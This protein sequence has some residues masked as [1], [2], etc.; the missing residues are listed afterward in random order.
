MCAQLF[1][2]KS[3]IN[4]SGHGG[5]TVLMK[6]ILKQT[7]TNKLAKSK[8][9][10]PGKPVFLFSKLPGA[11]ESMLGGDSTSVAAEADFV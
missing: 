4:L 11:Q 10:G 5:N 2:G 1:Y 9:M 8:D 7:K 6:E 3:L